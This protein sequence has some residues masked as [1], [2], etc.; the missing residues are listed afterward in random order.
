[1]HRLT[2]ENLGLHARISASDA[3]PATPVFGAVGKLDNAVGENKDIVR[4]ETKK[5]VGV[6]IADTKADLMKIFQHLLIGK[7][8]FVSEAAFDDPCEIRAIRLLCENMQAA[9]SDFV[10]HVVDDVD[11]LEIL[12]SD[13]LADR[14]VKGAIA[15]WDI[16]P[17]QAGT[18]GH[19]NA[20]PLGKCAMSSHRGEF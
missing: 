16:A 1:L 9:A 6:K 13:D 2:Y 10:A 3:H 15:E 4:I 8:A 11:L 14:P 19:S 18:V 12:E 5:T 20:N 17:D 7:R